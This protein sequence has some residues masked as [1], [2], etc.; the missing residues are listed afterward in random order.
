[1]HFVFVAMVLVISLLQAE[2][3]WAQGNAEAG[4]QLWAGNAIECSNCHGEE[5]EGGFGPDLAGR[6]LSVEQFRRAV[7]RPWGI[8]PAYIDTQISDQDMPI[9]AATSPMK[10]ENKGTNPCS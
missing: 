3:A 7:R 4:E 2:T 6:R 1:M 5:G 8:M 10:R 9:Q